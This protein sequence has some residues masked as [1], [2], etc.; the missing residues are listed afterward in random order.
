MNVPLIR[1]LNQQLISPQYR[2][3]EEVLTW[4]GMIQAQNFGAAKM[5]LAMR[6]KCSSIE[7]ALDMVDKALDRGSIIRTHVMRPTWQLVCAE[8]VRWMNEVSR[9]RIRRQ[10]DGYLKQT[11]T[12]VSEEEYGRALEL[13]KQW[14]KGGKA[15]TSDE[16][17][18][19]FSQHFPIDREHL[20]AYIWRAENSGIITSGSVL[21]NHST[22]ALMNERVPIHETVCRDEA[23]RRLARIY[24]RGHGPATLGD[25]CWWAGL[26]IGEARDAFLSI[27]D[28]E[29]ELRCDYAYHKD[30]RTHGK[31]AGTSLLLPAFDEYLIGYADRCEVLPKEYERR[32]FTRNGIFF[33]VRFEAGQ[34]VG[35]VRGGKETRFR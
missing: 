4:M 31:L 26:N 9:D 29:L 20:T 32:C 14:L 30:C 8:N 16:L 13:M 5:A 7:K 28:D 21:G 11:G 22:Y 27:V 18:E 1:S 34:I 10:V 17:K 19:A 2:T 12:I 15:M 24:W 33:P 35:S 6:M 23:L 3:P 25:F